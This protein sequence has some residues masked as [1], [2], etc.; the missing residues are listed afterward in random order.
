M[1]LYQINLTRVKIILQPRM[2]ILAGA[3]GKA[4]REWNHGLGQYHAEM[5]E[6]G[7]AVVLN[8]LW[9]TY[10]ALE[11]RRQGDAGIVLEHNDERRCFTVDGELILRFKHLN[12][13]YRPRNNWTVRAQAWETQ[14]W[15]PSIPPM[16]RLDFGYRL[17]LTGTSVLTAMVLFGNGK[18]T[19][20]RWQVW[21]HPVSEFASKPSVDMLGRRVYSHDDYSGAMLP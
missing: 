20:W 19:V 16:V 7:R 3:L 5:T 6:F 11:F 12:D 8:D 4:L 17:D 15:F 10:A 18:E 1:T 13:Q 14:A 2:P 9:Y 21:G